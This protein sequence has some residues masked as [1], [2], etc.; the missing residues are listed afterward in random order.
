MF[1]DVQME[2]S[3]DTLGS[4]DIWYNLTQLL[5]CLLLVGMLFGKSSVWKSPSILILDLICLST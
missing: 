4:F 5:L 2:C 1:C 3:I